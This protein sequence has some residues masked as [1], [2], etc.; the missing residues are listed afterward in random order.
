MVRP[1]T[2][3]DDDLLKIAGECFMEEG[4]H[5]A[6]RVIAE[7]AGISQPAL[8]KRFKTKENLL[9][10]ALTTKDTVQ[11][12]LSNIG[13]LTKHPTRDPLQPQLEELLTRVWKILLEIIPR[14]IALHAHKAAK[15]ALDPRRLISA[16]KTPP[17]IK[18]L[19]A[20]TGFV[21]RAQK[22]NQIQKNLDARIV[23]MNIMGPVQGRVFFQQI[24]GLQMDDK[25][26][27]N[28]IKQTASTLCNGFSTDGERK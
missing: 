25:S 17:P 8:F 9:M 3:S 13:W 24:M 14:M 26:N 11:L 16:F 19:E 12:V 2:I 6:T 22:N 1:K 23:A 4:P 21:E 20:V 15:G 28:F 5:V 18:M 7:R 27:K 10:A